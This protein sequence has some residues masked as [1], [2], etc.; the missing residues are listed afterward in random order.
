MAEDD[1][2]KPSVLPQETTNILKH[3]FNNKYGNATPL[4]RL[5]LP[6]KNSRLPWHFTTTMQ[7][8]PNDSGSILQIFG[9][10]PPDEGLGWCWTTSEQYPHL[11]SSKSRLGLCQSGVSTTAPCYF[12]DYDDETVAYPLISF[13]VKLSFPL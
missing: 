10:F 1:T 11:Y 12:Y 3:L 9:I 8:Q 5:G 2:T 6:Q 4:Q 13:F 7:Q